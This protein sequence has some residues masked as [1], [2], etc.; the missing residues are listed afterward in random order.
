[1]EEFFVEFLKVYDIT[2]QRFFEKLQN[3]LE[4]LGI[5]ISNVRGKRCD[6]ESNMKGKH[7]G[8]QRKLLDVDPRALYKMFS[9]SLVSW[10]NKK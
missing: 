5:D 8:V 4:T 10:H 9:N 2:G 1:M 7:Q 3:V 6:N